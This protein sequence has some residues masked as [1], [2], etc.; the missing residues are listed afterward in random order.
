[1]ACVTCYGETVLY[2][3][4]GCPDLAAE[5]ATDLGLRLGERDVEVFPNSNTFVRLGSSVR[6]QDTFIIQTTSAPVNDNLMELLIF[7]DTLK[8]ASAG[9]VTA[10]RR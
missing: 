8:R 10:L 2:G 7:I 9:R 1:M 5:M 6:G 3:G 4:T